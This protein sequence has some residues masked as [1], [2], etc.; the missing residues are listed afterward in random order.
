MTRIETHA[1]A[2]TAIRQWDAQAQAHWGALIV[3]TAEGAIFTVDLTREQ[4]AA[5]VPELERIARA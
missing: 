2:I 5:L 4:A 1:K 3:H